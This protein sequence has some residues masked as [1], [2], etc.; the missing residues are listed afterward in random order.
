MAK[1]YDVTYRLDDNPHESKIVVYSKS[2]QSV[3]DL[4]VSLYGTVD[5]LKIEDQSNNNNIQKDEE[6]TG[7][8][9]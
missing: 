4:L 7:E 5:I 1:Y 2:E 9:E 3:R 8:E 6:S